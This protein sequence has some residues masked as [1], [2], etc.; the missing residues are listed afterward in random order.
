MGPSFKGGLTMVDKDSA[1][2]SQ[3]RRPSDLLWHLSLQAIPERRRGR[4][5]LRH[6]GLLRAP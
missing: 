5:G 3:A 2:G 6:S 1:F 4:G